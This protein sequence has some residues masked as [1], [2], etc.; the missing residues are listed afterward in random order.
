MSVP[1]ARPQ[2][3]HFFGTPL[4]IEPSPGQLSGHAGL[5]PIRQFDELGQHVDHTEA[6]NA[7]VT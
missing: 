6:P 2:V 5:F 3:L 7:R 1:L 4:V